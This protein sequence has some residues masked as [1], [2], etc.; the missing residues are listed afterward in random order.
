MP[1]NN[2]RRHFLFLD[3]ETTGLDTGT[4]AVLEIATALYDPEA[5]IVAGKTHH[6]INAPSTLAFDNAAYRMHT[7]SGLHADYAAGKQVSAERASREIRRLVE[8]Y[9][10][11][12]D[13][14]CL[15]GSGVAEYDRR[16]IERVFP[17]INEL[18]HWRAVDVGIFRRMWQDMTR[19]SLPAAP[20]FQA[21]AH[22]ASDDVQQSIDQYRW[23][24]TQ[25][26]QLPPAP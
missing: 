4:C 11:P 10:N 15:A 8:Q 13:E 20:M 25:L 18:L 24:K 6:Y 14:V 7:A 26:E 19:S 5:D 1:S 17:I 12:G 23:F 21:P 22:R 2:R 3:L 9:T 16:I